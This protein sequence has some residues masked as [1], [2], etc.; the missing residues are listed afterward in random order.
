MKADRC[1][2]AGLVF[3]FGLFL[4]AGAAVCAEGPFEADWESLA[5]HEEAPEW[6]RD[7]KFGIY[8]HWGVYCVPA[9]GN[10]WYPRNMHIKSG[11][12]YRHHL[13][14]WGEPTEF[15]YHDFVPMFKAEKFDAEEWAELFA[16]AGA[17][18]AGP[19]AEHHD[20]FA[21]WAS[22]M[23]P[24][25][26][27]AM[28][29]KRD[30]TGEIAA[31]VR[32]RGMKLVATFHHAR[33]NLWQKD[34]RNWTG[35]Y[36]RVKT[37]FASLLED[38]EQA[39]LYGYMP[40]GEFLEMWKGKL[41]EVIDKYEPDLMWFDSWLDEIPDSYKTAYLA[42]YFNHAAKREKGVVVTYK[43]EDLPQ[44][45]GVLDLE[46]G[47]MDRLTDFAWLTDDTIS[48]GS[49]CY[50]RDL[51]I[52]PTR[53]VLHSLID[54]VS[55]NGQLLLNISPKADGTI[56]AEQQKVLREMGA[57]LRVN[58]EAIYNTRPWQVFGEGPTDRS[59]PKG[60]F[61]G[62]ADPRGGYS[63]QDI[64]FTRSKD[65]KTLYAIALGWPGENAELVIR[66]FGKDRMR[67][68]LKVQGVSMLGSEAKIAYELRD[69]GLAVRTPGKKVDDMA[70]VFRIETSGSA[71]ILAEG[72]VITLSAEAAVLD[73]GR[74]Q[75][76]EKYGRTN[77]GFW[78]DPRESVHWLVRITRAGEYVV[79]GEFAAAS[80][81][82]R[83][84][85]RCRRNEV[86]FD[87]PRTVGW[88]KAAQVEIGKLAFDEAGVYHVS[89][90]PAA[91]ET[92]KAVNVWQIEL[93]PVR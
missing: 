82:S 55:K 70:V 12:E 20:G 79:G 59:L 92:W 90:R 33:N 54:I 57:W 26:A 40:R 49:W 28:G 52:K 24:W 58:G 48:L 32:K 76:E 91:A 68:D 66:S 8:F 23:T 27:G 61:G 86:T 53:V 38:P 41:V 3:V 65:G 75:T 39:I 5:R 6:F 35:H 50:T 81:A 7:A 18:F 69:D 62:V 29:P 19:V 34:G 78:D 74:I 31:A 4:F 85:L 36:D 77:I 13:E 47:R 42:Y 1:V 2:V 45:V 10:E 84:V 46:K 73:G 80:G 11:R 16:E 60:Q 83:L 64:R 30:I 72:D 25:N 88:D 44:D 87:V 43:Q 71:V 9:F 89:L 37:D 93:I 63:P 17:R 56:P 22:K 15:G 67:G 21:M 51:R 14:T